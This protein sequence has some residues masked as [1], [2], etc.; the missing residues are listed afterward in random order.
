M[1]VSVERVDRKKGGGR[2]NCVRGMA[3]G[4]S[5]KVCHAAADRCREGCV[6]LFKAECLHL[7]LSDYI[8]TSQDEKSVILSISFEP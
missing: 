6:S 1:W 2:W 8:I 3:V 5:R 7:S 4:Q